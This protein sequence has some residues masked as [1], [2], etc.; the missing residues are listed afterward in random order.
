MTKKSHNKK[1]NVGIIYEQLVLKLSKAVV[2]NDKKTFRDTRQIIKKYFKKG[3]ELYKEHRLVN[4]LADFQTTQMSV[5]PT[6]LDETKKAT[7]RI[8]ERKLDR[9]KSKLIRDINETFGKSFYST[10]VGNYRDLA[11]IDL[12]L[13]EYRKGSNSDHARLLEYSDKVTTILVKKKDTKSVDNMKS[14]EINNLVVSLMREKFSKAYVSNLSSDQINLINEWVIN[15]TTQELIS[16]MKA[17]KT[18]CL[19]VLKN[20]QQNCSNEFLGRNLVEVYSNVNSTKFDD[21]ID[22]THIIRTMT[23]HDIIKELSGD[24]NE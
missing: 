21:E 15:G 16:E 9:E 17:T 7:W 12:L 20:Y 19:D 8:N 14:P 22:E 11:T 18:I 4:S 23:M 6:I 5:I 1:R 24:E 2:E 10:R 3:T 13:Q